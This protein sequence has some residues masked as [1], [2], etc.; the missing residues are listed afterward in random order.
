MITYKVEYWTT[1]DIHL[2]AEGYGSEHF[3]P[4]GYQEPLFSWYSNY[5]VLHH[6]ITTHTIVHKLYNEEFKEKRQ[7]KPWFFVYN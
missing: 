3:A 6:C 2:A 5:Q 7:R 1:A 4:A